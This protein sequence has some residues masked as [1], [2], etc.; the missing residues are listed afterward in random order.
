MVNAMIHPQIV[1]NM[2]NIINGSIYGNNQHTDPH[3]LHPW[4]LA[5]GH[6]VG[7]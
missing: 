2:T 3:D 6:I 7:C 1:T 4:T 5:T